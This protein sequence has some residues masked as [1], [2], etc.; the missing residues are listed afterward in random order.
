MSSKGP[1]TKYHV[2]TSPSRRSSSSASLPC[3]KDRQYRSR[4]HSSTLNLNRSRELIS[5]TSRQPQSDEDVV[6]VVMG[7]TGSGK[8][9]L[10]NLLADERVKVGHS[11]QSCTTEVQV[12][13]F[14]TSAGRQAFLID[15]PGFDDT[16]RNDTE[17]LKEIAAFLTKLYVRGI[18]VTG[19]VYVHRITDPKMQGS[20]V[21]NLEVFQKLC[22]PQCFSQVAL[23]ST[24]WQEL[25]GAQAQALGEEREAE[26]RGNVNFWGAMNQGGSR[27]FRHFGKRKSAEEVFQWFLSLRHKVVLNIQRELVED[28]LTLDQTEAGKFLQETSARVKEK[29]EREILQL[30]IGIDDAHQERDS[31]TEND[32]LLQ[33]NEAKA[34]LEKVD[35]DSRDMHVSL[36]QLEAEKGPEYAVRVEEMEREKSVNTA[37]SVAALQTKLKEVQDEMHSLRQACQQR[38]KEL[39][40]QVEAIRSQ[41]SAKAQDKIIRLEAELHQVKAQSRE[42]TKALE[43]LADH[44]QAES[45]FPHG[46]SRVLNFMM[47]NFAP[48]FRS[49]H[50]PRPQYIEQDSM[51]IA[52][53]R[54]GTSDSIQSTGRGGGDGR[55]RYER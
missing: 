20:A 40:Q 49:R 25:G 15:T 37:P 41:R 30:Q 42:Q 24:M 51:V 1:V 9:T 53:R 32:L 17:I 16:N 35:R 33:R 10:I 23:V 29:Y 7:M 47:D 44:L 28:E 6:I 18:H 5:S 36:L 13:S 2:R 3:A 27:T 11:L 50:D 45:P 43:D 26:L 39:L 52:P 38:E 19:L 48:V 8:S 12:A 14:G 31:Q 22:G 54:A 21:K 34:A 46:A 4:S 55:S